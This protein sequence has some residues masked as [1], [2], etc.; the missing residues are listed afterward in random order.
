[1]AALTTPRATKKYK[2]TLTTCPECKKELNSETNS[3]PHCGFNFS[4][5][6]QVE[7]NH[8]CAVIC[9]TFIGLILAI[10]LLGSLPS[11]SPTIVTSNVPASNSARKDSPNWI[12]GESRDQMNGKIYKYALNKSL[13]TENFKFP[14]Q[15]IQ[16][17]TIEV[18]GNM[19]FFYIEQGQ[20][21]CNGGN[22]FGTCYIRIKFDNEKDRLVKAK[23][24]GDDSTTIKFI[25]PGFFKH[26]KKSKQ[27]MVQPEIFHNGYPIFTFDTNELN[28]KN[29]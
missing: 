27:L 16:H 19:I 21:V 29:L 13:N 17:A 9:F 8:G 4:K 2:M 11:K 12:Y 6:K 20:I 10:A 22:Q 18:T 7:P 24:S 1:M 28:V 5:T 14:Y 15:G 25:E 3:C 26:L 23:K